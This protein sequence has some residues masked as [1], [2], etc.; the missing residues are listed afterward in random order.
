M[1]HKII[2]FINLLAIIPLIFCNA[3]A[4]RAEKPARVLILPFT[5]HSDKDLTFLKDGITDMLSTRLTLEGKLLPLSKGETGQEI[6]SLSESVDEQ[7]AISLGRKLGADYVS[8]GSLT[9]FGDSISTD[10]RFFD[11]HKNEPLVI[12]YESGKGHS[13]V[14]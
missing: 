2:L 14:I 3:V 1:K 11:L 8:Y 13:D 9:V 7:T 4:V 12:F 6:K 5:V 10:A